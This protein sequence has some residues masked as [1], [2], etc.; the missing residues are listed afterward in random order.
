MLN[1]SPRGKKGNTEILTEAFLAGIAKTD[2]GARIDR[3]Y[4]NTLRI[5][6][7]TGCFGCWNKTPGKCVIRDD[8]EAV[9]QK[10]VEAD[11]IIYATPLYH[12]GMTAQ[13]KRLIER[14]LPIVKPYMV[15]MGNQYMH[16]SRYEKH[17]QKHILISNCGF[18][19][20]H[21]FDNLVAHMNTIT[22]GL[23]ETILCTGGEML[24]LKEAGNLSGNYLE[25]VEQAGLEFAS[26]GSIS[27]GTRMEL[28]KSFIELTAFVNMAN[29]SW[30]VPGDTAPTLEEVHGIAEAQN[31]GNILSASALPENQGG[32]TMAALMN[33]MLK[34][35]DGETAKEMRMTLE[36]DFTDIGESYYFVIKDGT[37]ALREGHAEKP[38]TTIMA[39]STVWNDI[40]AG[41][42]NGAT[43]MMQGLYSV[44][45]D[46]GFM[47]KFSKVF[48]S[49]FRR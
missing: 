2:K 28:K 41:R 10:Y 42:K 5:Q 43:A 47:M 6:D 34:N 19:E 22:G 15:K 30:N 14:T 9:L 13:L 8:M 21:H 26:G 44:K 1:G 23:A 32:K 3:V 40:S 18:P 11:V 35:F 12:F 27:E 49:G 46:F 31:P 48:P 33:G 16:P 7:C 17:G 45:G 37:C 29:S 38:T 24:G 25:S 39:P 36:M 20:I 4:T